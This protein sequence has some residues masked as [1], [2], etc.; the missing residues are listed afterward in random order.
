MMLL[1]FRILP[2][3]EATSRRGGL[4]VAAHYSIVM[5]GAYESGFLSV[6]RSEM[7]VVPHAVRK[8]ERPADLHG[9]ENAVEVNPLSTVIG[10]R[11]AAE[12]F[13]DSGGDDR[14]LQG[15]KM[16]ASHG[17]TRERATAASWRI[18]PRW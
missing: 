7:G 15:G 9:V 8:L 3:F 17:R 13:L 4:R 12:R 11:L 6:M 5:D 10:P 14:G 18:A 1:L 16:L 2:S